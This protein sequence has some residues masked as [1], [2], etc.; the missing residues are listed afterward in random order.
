MGRPDS[1]GEGRAEAARCRQR[2]GDHGAG[3]A[4]LAGGDGLQYQKKIPRACNVHFLLPYEVHPCAPSPAHRRAS[5]ASKARPGS[6]RRAAAPAAHHGPRR[7]TA[8]SLATRPT[9]ISGSSS[10][11]AHPS[12]A[13]GPRRP[14]EALAASFSSPSFLAKMMSGRSRAGRRQLFRSLVPPESACRCSGSTSWRRSRSSCW[15]GS[16]GEARRGSRSCRQ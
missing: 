13:R 5:R 3:D 15:A 12:A 1:R 10:R 8:S 6:L 4:H 7:R 14:C 16:T 11:P 2:G 9:M